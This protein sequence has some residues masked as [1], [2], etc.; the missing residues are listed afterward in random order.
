MDMVT[1]D[2]VGS[3]VDGDTA[4]VATAL[5]GTLLPPPNCRR[6]SCRARG[7]P[8]NHNIKVRRTRRY[9]LDEGPMLLTTVIRHLGLLI[10]AVVD[11]F[12]LP[13]PLEWTEFQFNY[14]PAMIC[15]AK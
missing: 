12:L 2:N 3:I 13:C 15:L 14:V 11:Y 8:L 6:F 4:P 7:M 10:N 1:D 5:D 9:L